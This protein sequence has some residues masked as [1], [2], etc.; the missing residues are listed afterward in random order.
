MGHTFSIAI[1]ERVRQK[2]V[3]IDHSSFGTGVYYLALAILRGVIIAE[4]M[5]CRLIVSKHNREG[6]KN[7]KSNLALLLSIKS[8]P[9]PRR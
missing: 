3:I 8:S 1:D 4:I 6:V 5:R 9:L 7:K 2:S